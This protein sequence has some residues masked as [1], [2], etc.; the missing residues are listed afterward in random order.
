MGNYQSFF[1]YYTSTKNINKMKKKMLLFYISSMFAVCITAQIP[2]YDA[3]ELTKYVDVST[4]PH[5]FKSD[6]PS[7]Q[8]VS[9][10]LLKYCP[11]LGQDRDYHDVINAI[12]T[13]N[14]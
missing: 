14:A 12:I 10:I 5:K 3:V 4:T 11:N 8:A 7:L 6:V 13:N 9:K 1:G 2:Y